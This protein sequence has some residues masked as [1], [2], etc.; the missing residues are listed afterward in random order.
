M[1][2]R[3]KAIAISIEEELSL[4][5]WSLSANFMHYRHG[6]AQLAIAGIADPSGR[7]EAY[8]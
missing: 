7:D 6:R 3:H 4:T 1:Q 2:V 8:S 5:P